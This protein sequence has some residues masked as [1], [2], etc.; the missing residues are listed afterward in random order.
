V[1]AEG[2][3]PA[4]DDGLAGYTTDDD[5]VPMEQYTEISDGDDDI[6][7][8]GP[9]A[10]WDWATSGYVF[11]LDD[12]ADL[13]LTG[14][15]PND[16]GVFMET[17]DTLHTTDLHDTYSIP[18][19]VNPAF[20]CHELPDTDDGIPHAGVTTTTA[21][22]AE[23]QTPTTGSGP[24]AGVD[25]T[26]DDGEGN[27]GTQGCGG[28]TEDNG[29][30][31]DGM[32]RCG[33]GGPREGPADVGATAMTAHD[34]EHQ[35]PPTGSE[36]GAGVDGTAETVRAQKRKH[37][38]GAEPDTSQFWEITEDDVRHF[39]RIFSAVNLGHYTRPDCADAV[40][41]LLAREAMASSSRPQQGCVGE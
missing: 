17:P 39:I 8:D 7:H 14:P 22:D 34:A 32:E 4:D 41:F 30:G 3:T 29:D 20:S 5:D 28:G 10:D 13:V 15:V 36:P 26:E 27:D 19:P 40:N 25:G 37:A 35:T 31:N 9:P 2:D 23:P 33:W 18:N 21:L 6:T 12:P 1:T 11:G 16:D 24:G 38:E